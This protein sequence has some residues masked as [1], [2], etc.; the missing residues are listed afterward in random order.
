MA[1]KPKPES[2]AG[3][4]TGGV[5]LPEVERLLAF[6]EKHGLEEFEYAHGDFHVRVRKPFS[7][8]HSFSRAASGLPDIVVAG[9][10]PAAAHAGAGHASG[11]A[12]AGGAAGAEA[13]RSEDVHTVKSPIVGTFY[14][15]ATP[16]SEPF[17]AV[18]SK[19][20]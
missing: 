3:K 11:A 19:V 8:P 13:A 1:K 7:Q 12:A 14:S 18:G 5:D 20:E 9:A 15:A 16:G 4:R 2:S 10:A 17:V 6:M